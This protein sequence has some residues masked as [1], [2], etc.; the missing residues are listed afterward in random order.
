MGPNKIISLKMSKRVYGGRSM[1]AAKRFR[2]PPKPKGYYT[3]LRSTVSSGKGTLNNK[4]KTVVRALNKQAPEIKYADST[5][6]FTNIGDP[7]TLTPF[8]AVAQGDGFADRSGNGINLKHMTL[9]LLVSRILGAAPTADTYVRLFVVKDKQG[10]SDTAPVTAAEIFTGSAT[11]AM[12][13][14]TNLTRFDVIWRSQI[15]DLA[16]LACDADG[17]PS[18]VPTQSGAIEMDLSISGMVQ[19][20]GAASTD[21]QK[22]MY[23]LVVLTSDTNDTLDINGIARTC[24][25]DA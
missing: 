22:N 23:Y 2:G 18:V 3:K 25:T 10:I 9:R 16:R 17:V 14:L 7:G 21:Y 12:V 5:L 24:F 11:T 19:Y 8:F 6:S 15:I 20:N 4:L 13:S 1:P